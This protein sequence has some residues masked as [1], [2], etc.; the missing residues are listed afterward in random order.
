MFIFNLFYNFLLVHPLNYQ[1]ATY[2]LGFL[3]EE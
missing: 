1:K 3:L 2:E